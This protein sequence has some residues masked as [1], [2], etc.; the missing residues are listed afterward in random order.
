MSVINNFISYFLLLLFFNVM[1]KINY[2][3]PN[4]KT[5][6]GCLACLAG[7]NIGSGNTV[8]EECDGNETLFDEESYNLKQP[9]KKSVWNE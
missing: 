2:Q 4:I 5:M 7:I 6:E 9:E 3:S 1:K 8:P